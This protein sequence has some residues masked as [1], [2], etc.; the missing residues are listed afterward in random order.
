MRIGESAARL[1]ANPAISWTGLPDRL[2]GSAKD[3]ST[4]ITQELTMKRLAGLVPSFRK[5]RLVEGAIFTVV[6]SL[7]IPALSAQQPQLVPQPRELQ[8]TGQNFE[9]KPDTEIV[10]TPNTASEDRFAAEGLE[11]ELKLVTGRNYAIV[12]SAGAVHG[13]AIRLARFGDSSRDSAGANTSG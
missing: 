9:V 8:S 7:L 13:P 4:P 5:L 1:H 3:D 10:L 11:E 12:S 6:A 2:I